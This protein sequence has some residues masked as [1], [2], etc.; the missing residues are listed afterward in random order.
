MNRIVIETTRPGLLASYRILG[1]IE[2]CRAGHRELTLVDAPRPFRCW[3]CA[4][5][6]ARTGEV[7]V[8]FDVQD[9][10]MAHNYTEWITGVESIKTGVTKI[11]IDGRET[12]SSPIHRGGW[13][14]RLLRWI[15]P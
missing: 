1:E 8:Q 7:R 6:L 4:R 3:E 5:S 15:R 9:D 11:T 10:A 2:T 13:L 12:Y 14:R